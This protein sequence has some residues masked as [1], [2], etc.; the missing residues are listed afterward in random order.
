MAAL[1]A[2][3]IGLAFA[4]GALG[5]KLTAPKPT[6]AG[7]GVPGQGHTRRTPAPNDATT[8]P[9]PPPDVAANQSA[10]VKSGYGAGYRQ[11]RRALAG[12]TSSVAQA[13]G[14]VLSPVLAPKTLI[15]Y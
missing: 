12:T 1:T 15:G 2:A 6:S 7:G 13:S 3:L 10:A 9:P 5:A 4:G 11:R 14:T 8:T